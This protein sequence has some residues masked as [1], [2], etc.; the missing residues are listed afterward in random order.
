MMGK[1]IF[2]ILHSKF[3]FVITYSKTCVKQP[4]SERPQIGCLD[5][6]SLNAGQ[7]YCRM[8]QGEHSAILLTFIKLT[9]VIKIFVLSIFE[10]PFYTGFTV[11][12]NFEDKI[13][14]IFNLF[15]SARFYTG[16]KVIKLFSCSTQLS[17]KFILLINVKIPT[18]VGILTFISMLNTTSERLKQET[19]SFV[20]ILVF[21]SN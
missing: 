15:E 17:M 18:I 6:L 10:W 5:Q 12:N 20:G 1:K 9:F 7:K 3:L 19:S 13:V 8:L 16:P 2:T 21:M 14:N 4:L 11:Y